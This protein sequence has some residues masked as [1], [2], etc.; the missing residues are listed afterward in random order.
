MSEYL[1][2]Y[3]VA[4]QISGSIF[5]R[6]VALGLATAADV[7]STLWNSLPLTPNVK[8]ED[9]LEQ[10][11]KDALS[12]YQENTDTVRTLSLI[13]GSFVPAGIGVKLLNRA[14]AGLTSVGYTGNFISESWAGVRQVRLADEIKDIFAASGAETAAYKATSNKIMLANLTKEVLDNTAIELAVVGTMNA[15]PYMEDYWKDPLK[16]FALG[17][18]FG[19]AIGG[20]FA[21]PASRR[22]VMDATGEIAT[23]GLSIVSSGYRQVDEAFTNV[24]KFQA[25]T[26][27]SQRLQAIADN[28]EYNGFTRAVAENAVLRESAKREEALLTAAPWAETADEATKK[29]LIDI[30]SDPRMIGVD[31]IS[32]KNMDRAVKATANPAT[33]LST[34][35]MLK[36]MDAGPYKLPNGTT[37]SS[38]FLTPEGKGALVYVRLGTKEIFNPVGARNAALAAD[39]PD[40]LT[41]IQ[42]TPKGSNPL[43]L[44]VPNFF[45]DNLFRAVSS[46]QNDLRFLQEL[47]YVN[48]AD[49][50]K[51]SYLTSAP[52]DLARMNAL[53]SRF[54]T[55]TPDQRASIKVQIRSDL[56]SYQE[57]QK[58]VENV[59]GK[60]HIPRIN[61]AMDQYNWDRV[62]SSPQA[63]DMVSSWVRGD[64]ESKAKLRRAMDSYLRGT[65]LP[66]KEAGN[67]EIAAELWQQGE[68]FRAALRKT[69]DGDGYVYLYRGIHSDVPRG[70]GAVESY[71]TRPGV[72]ENFGTV[73]LYRVHVDNVIGAIGSKRL[74]EYEVL[75]GAPHNEIVNA[76]PVGNTSTPANKIVDV[77]T[78]GNRYE[79]SAD[80]LDLLHAEETERQILELAKQNSP[81]STNPFSTEEISARL[82]VKKDAVV[83]VLGGHKLK[84]VGEE[85]GFEWRR[86]I[87]PEKIEKDYLSPQN[88]LYAVA[89]NPV[90]NPNAESMANLDARQSRLMHMESVEHMTELHDSLIGRQVLEIYRHQDVKMALDELMDNIGQINN[91][92]IGDPRWQSAD[93]LLRKFISRPLVTHIGKQ[94]IEQTDALKRELL[95]P[96]AASLLPMKNNPAYLAEFNKVVNKLYSM[97]GWRELRTRVTAS[98]ETEGFLVQMNKKGV[99]TTVLNED[100]SEFLIKQSGVI[101]AL[102]AM[103]RPSSELLKMHNLNRAITGRPPLNDLGFY[104]PPISLINKNYAF[105]IDNSGTQNVRLLAANSGP[106]LEDLIQ[107]FKRTSEGALP[108][109]QIVR[110]G[111]QDAFNYAKGYTDYESFT[112]YANVAFQH[113]GSSSLAIT[114]SN[115]RFVENFMSSYE[116]LLLQSM[117]QYSETYMHNVTGWLDNMSAYYKRSIEGQPKKPEVKESAKDSALTV[118]NILLGR[119]QLEQSPRLKAANT[120]TDMLLNKAAS[121][122]NSVIRINNAAQTE[123]YFTKLNASLKANGVEPIWKSFDEYLA[124]TRAESKNVSANIISAGNGMLATMQLRLFEVAQA[125]V[126]IMSLP[127]LTWSALMEKLPGTMIN[128]QGDQVKFP[129]RAMYAGIRQMFS[130]EAKQ[131]DELFER[132]GYTKQ[133]VREYTETVGALK[134]ASMGG[135]LVDQGVRAL[136]NFQKSEAVQ[137]LSKPSD[138]AEQFTRRYVMHTGFWAAKQAYPGLNDIGATIAAA[139]FADRAI[140]N[141][142]AAQRPTAFQGTLGAAVGLYQTY[143]LTFAQHIYRGL[144]ERNFGQL[145]ALAASQ[146]GIFGIGSWPGFNLISEQ[147]VSRFN[148]K[149]YDLTT[150]TFR[151]ADKDTAELILYGL[152]SSLGPAFYTRG[153]ISPRIPSTMGEVAILN[154]VK[155]GY[156]AAVQIIKKSGEG[157]SN[158][159]PVQSLFEAL[160]LQSINRPIARWSELVTG[161]SLTRQGNTVSPQNEVWTPMGVG[162]RL[163]A[164]RPIEEQ[165]L[166]NARHLDTFYGQ[167]DFERRQAAVSKLKT[168]IRNGKLDDAV[169]SDA[170]ETYLRFGGSA[171]G[172]QAA[173]NEAMISSEGGTR[174]GLMRKLEP[175]SPINRMISDLY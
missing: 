88:R 142:H 151:A 116:N 61:Q 117:R 148:D 124:T 136:R 137:L 46:A 101:D 58:V 52:D 161:S 78:K 131:L 85:I 89:G 104:V 160:S 67:R 123:E 159:T 109:M 91:Q 50:S 103:R 60:D 7:V 95:E 57:A 23:Q 146:A 163:L 40:A 69:A 86:Y 2:K 169:I 82:G 149:H 83:A 70:H 90:K 14:R 77:Q 129:L 97:E 29:A 121:A 92:L 96:L 68:K 3:D 48:K 20:A 56:P 49:I 174:L 134:S 39:L 80:E 45:E 138:W 106:E 115:E 17:A 156:N 107:S 93:N 66:R 8:T 165:V 24:G 126:N 122:V 105:V 63:L 171:K 42:T 170:A 54:A 73:N 36:L 84:D 87:D 158:G 111:D 110:K 26:A 53:R 152:P 135:D 16:N 102:E 43:I 100:N 172:W 132:L 13:G 154:G 4:S 79:I 153:D 28:T 168:G 162:A 64:S 25:H 143:F 5:N 51:L 175:D 55:M 130:P 81:N 1:E 65:Q 32:H 141:Y 9:I 127:I 75:V 72:S 99:E 34:E 19:A 144:E 155:E 38:T 98:G 145:A 21:V 173:L 71:S 164:T 18:G 114:P 112:T 166:R 31:K 119:D 133:G 27:N 44:P 59:V 10:V 118:K 15:H 167:V 157:V 139:S 140:G 113:R 30:M 125:S 74:N 108:H 62:G 6:P 22:L 76:I 41:K 37:V 128:P 147:V 11:D 12:L 47:Y 35:D 120:L 150:G 33:I 94:V